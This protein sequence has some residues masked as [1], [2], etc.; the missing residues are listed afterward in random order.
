MDRG[1]DLNKIAAG[2]Y[3]VDLEPL[4]YEG[5]SFAEDIPEAT[6]ELLKIDGTLYGIPNWPRKGAPAATTSGSS[7]PAFGK[8]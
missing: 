2:G 8:L 3:L 5:C 4:M 6:R 7:T 1:P